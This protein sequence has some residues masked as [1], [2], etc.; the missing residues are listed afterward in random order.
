MNENIYFLF[1]HFYLFLI[2]YL[3][4]FIYLSIVQSLDY[5]CNRRYRATQSFTL[6]QEN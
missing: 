6:V 5:G 4:S 2:I 1:I 3:Y